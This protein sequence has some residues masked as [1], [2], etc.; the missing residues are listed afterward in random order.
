MEIDDQV[1]RAN[2]SNAKICLDFEIDFCLTRPSNQ[3]NT[4][5]S[6]TWYTGS[7]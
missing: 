2:D 7:L 6:R 5:M 1:V 3:S 4:R